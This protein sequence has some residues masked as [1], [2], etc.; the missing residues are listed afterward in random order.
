MLVWTVPVQ[1]NTHELIDIRDPTHPVSSGWALQV[2]SDLVGGQVK[3]PAVY[4]VTNDA[5]TIQLDKTFNRLFDQ[6]G[7]NYPIIV[8]FEKL[9]ADATSKIII[10]DERVINETG[11]EWIDYHMI[12]IV[13][14]SSNP[15]AGFDPGFIPDGDQLEYVSY[16]RNVGYDGLPIQLNFMDTDGSGVPSSLQVPGG[17]NWFQPGYYSDGRIVIVPDPQLE[18]G[19]H[20]GLKEIPTVPE[21]ATVLLLGI[22]GLMT[23]IRRGKGNHCK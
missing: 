23:L 12:L 20:F 16:A 7:F 8:E 6:Y 11:R 18:V 1:G 22:G 13:N 2:R 15:E 9:S 19:G 5:V 14:D 3:W 17:E 21:P 10:K 4:G